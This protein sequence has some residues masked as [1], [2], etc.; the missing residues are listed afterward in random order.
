MTAW[1]NDCR[2]CRPGI[3]GCERIPSPDRILGNSE[4][5]RLTSLFVK[6]GYLLSIRAIPPLT[7]GEAMEV[8][9]RMA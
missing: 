9:L 8:P 2:I 5:G 4:V 1:I 6:S 7:T 3:P